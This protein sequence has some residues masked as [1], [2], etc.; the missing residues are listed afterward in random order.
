VDKSRARATGGFGLGLA[1]VKQIVEAHG[2]DISVNADQF[3]WQ[4]N[5]KDGTYRKYEE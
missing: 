3:N 2:G 1:I 5:G 4:Q